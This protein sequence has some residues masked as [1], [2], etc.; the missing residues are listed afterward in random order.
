MFCLW[1]CLPS[2][3]D[4]DDFTRSNVEVPCYYPLTSAIEYEHLLHDGHCATALKI[5]DV[6][7]SYMPLQSIYYSRPIGRPCTYPSNY[8]KTAERI[9]TKLIREIFRCI[10]GPFRFSFS[11]DNFNDQFALNVTAFLRV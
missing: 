3:Y 5:K 6:V 8:S 10:V 1:K 11:L 7:G 2:R 9:F 4:R